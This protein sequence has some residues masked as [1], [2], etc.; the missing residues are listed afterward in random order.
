M[1][2]RYRLFLRRAS[3]YYA[4]DDQTKRFE[5]LKTK[6]RNEAL[7]LLHAKNEACHQPSINLHIARA[8]LMASDPGAKTRTWRHVMEEMI[9]IKSGE[10]QSRWIRAALDPAFDV[11]RNVPVV[12]TR[13][14]QFLSVL[15]SGTVST[16][17]YL[18]RL[19]NFALDV[20]WLPCPILPRRQWPA[21]HYGEHRAITPEEHRRIVAAENNP[22][23]RAFYELCWHLGGSQGDIAQLTA[24]DVNWDDRTVAYRRKKTRE[25]ALIHFG[26]VAAEILQSL[27]RFG[28]LF[29]SLLPMRAAHRA[30]EFKRVCRRTGIKGVTLHSYRYAWAERAKSAGYPERFAQ[31]ALGHTSKAVH[32]AYAKQ[33]QVSVPALE[34]FEKKAKTVDLPARIVP[35]PGKF[36]AS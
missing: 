30:T 19:H 2:P 6:N 22:E 35:L 8:Y 24:E 26:D 7:R 12:E 27:P 18:R 13:V 5:S 16:N 28:P 36:H 14:E 34:D 17:V 23:R 11:I 15:S 9:R 29:P 21:V 4:F 25:S 33:A 31:L 32:R 20:N 1:K 3:V 10:T